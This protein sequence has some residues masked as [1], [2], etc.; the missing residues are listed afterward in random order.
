MASDGDSPRDDRLARIEEVAE[1]TGGGLERLDARHVALSRMESATLLVGFERAE[2]LTG[3]RGQTPVSTRIAEE[4][5][6]SQITLL[7][8]GETWFRAPAIHAF[9]DRL[10]DEGTL[11]GFDR[12]VFYGAGMCGYAAAA[13]SVAAPGALVVAL[14]PQATLN[15]RIAEWDRRFLR[16]RR[17][18]FTTRYGYAPDMLDAAARAFILYDP[19]QPLDA[20][21]AA[22]FTR[23]NVTKI[24]CRHLG[25]MLED[26]LLSLGILDDILDA[27]CEG[28]L[29]AAVL[30]R[31]LRARRDHP[32]YLRRLLAHLEAG[33]HEMRAA[34]LCRS[35]VNRRGGPRFRR[36]LRELSEK[37]EAGGRALPARR[38]R[39][40]RAPEAP[41]R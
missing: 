33:N 26:E 23:G 37:F 29:S 5:G 12:V 8:E 25:G 21:H 30:H 14:A 34:I 3:R 6:F 36:R 9:F 38:E 17:L 28:K 7:A 18:D 40:G 19:E 13:Y 2:S 24:R 35:V 11:D 27:A 39:P 20:M 4:S 10:I 1:E 31:L 22:L 16:H 15:P 41:Q 32:P